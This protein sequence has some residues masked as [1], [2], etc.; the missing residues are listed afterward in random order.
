[1]T[2]RPCLDCASN[3]SC[4]LFRV[5]LAYSADA[6]WFEAFCAFWERA[7]AVI[8]SRCLWNYVS[9]KV[10]KLLYK[11]FNEDIWIVPHLQH[12]NYFTRA[13]Q[14]LR[15]C[16]ACRA[17]SLTA[18]ASSARDLFLRS[19]FLETADQTPPSE[20]RPIMIGSRSIGAPLVV[21]VDNRVYTA[22]IWEYCIQSDQL[23]INWLHMTCRCVYIYTHTHTYTRICAAEARL[24]LS[25][26]NQ[27]MQHKESQH[28]EVNILNEKFVY[29]K[30]S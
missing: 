29:L 4:Q 13:G 11:L 8:H 16:A 30:Y 1:M 3:S 7:R 12:Y 27:N 24:C 26:R 25:R 15:Q 17:K 5:Q 19:A 18:G 6:I 21:S 9:H 2:T 20:Y 23:I 28:A 22:I 10:F 14:R